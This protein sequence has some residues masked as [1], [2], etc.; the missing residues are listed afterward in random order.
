[1]KK[2][3]ILIIIIIYG[4]LETFRWLLFHRQPDVII[5]TI[6]IYLSWI[7]FLAQCNV[8]EKDIRARF[9]KPWRWIEG[10]LLVVYLAL[11][12][13]TLFINS[14]DLSFNRWDSWVILFIPCVSIAAQ[15]VFLRRTRSSDCQA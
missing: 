5:V 15:G 9:P 12:I 6:M 8:E 1:M 2:P 11:V 3:Q 13:R 14:P 10:L 7:F 4:L